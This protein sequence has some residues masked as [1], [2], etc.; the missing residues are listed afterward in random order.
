LSSDRV[1]K[2][3]LQIYIYCSLLPKLFF[4]KNW[5]LIN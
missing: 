5:S 4:T 3:E 1:V 2:I